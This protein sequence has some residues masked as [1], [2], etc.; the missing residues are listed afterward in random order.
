MVGPPDYVPGAVRD[1]LASLV[2]RGTLTADGQLRLAVLADALDDHERRLALGL[3]DDGDQGGEP[4]GV[5]LA[6]FY[7]RLNDVIAAGRPT[8]GAGRCIELIE[9]YDRGDIEHW[10]R[11]L[12]RPGAVTPSS[13][14]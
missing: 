4:Y 5:L 3:P 14:R 7:C 11:L 2:G 12:E 6:R 13:T 8:A 1:L 9:A 10:R